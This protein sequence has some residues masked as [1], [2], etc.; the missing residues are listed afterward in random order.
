MA[1]GI[2]TGGRTSVDG[3]PKSDLVRVQPSKKATVQRF[4]AL[5]DDSSVKDVAIHALD[6][7]EAMARESSSGNHV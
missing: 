7:L 3:E 1:K 4:I 6:D 5:L 2:K